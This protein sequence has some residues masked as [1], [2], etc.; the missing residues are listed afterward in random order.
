MTVTT[1]LIGLGFLAI[2]ILAGSMVFFSAV[3]APLIFIKL[4]IETAGR[5]VRQVFP[6]Y[7][8]A[9]ILLAASGALFLVWGLPLNASLLALVAGSAMYCRQSLMPAI[10]AYRDQS[11]AGDQQATSTFERLHRRSEII[12]GLQILAVFAVLL[13]LVFVPIS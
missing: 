6:W 1:V 4:D 5:F 10:N 11:L 13:H 2:S 8:L 9:V 12:N 7:Y 3:M